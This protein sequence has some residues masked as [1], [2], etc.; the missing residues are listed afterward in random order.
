MNRKK[1]VKWL[2]S[3]MTTK[4]RDNGDIFYVFKDGVFEEIRDVLFENDFEINDY[5]YKWI[6]HAFDKIAEILDNGKIED[7]DLREQLVIDLEGDIYLYD[8]TEW[9]GDR[10]SNIYYI[11]E[12]LSFGV[13][14]GF[15]LLQLAQQRAKE[16][17]YLIAFEVYLFLKSK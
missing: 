9:L 17:V 2:E 16:D 8:L 5:Y 1:I 12:A 15:Q 10:N 3:A 11:D 6:S 14:D 4:T 13:I 7:D